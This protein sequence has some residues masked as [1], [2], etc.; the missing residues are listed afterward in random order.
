M[1]SDLSKVEVGDEIWTVQRGWVEVLDKDEHHVHIKDD[2]SYY[3]DGFYD[4]DHAHASA[5]TEYPFGI[6]EIE[7][8]TLVYCRDRPSL[9][10]Y[11][12]YYSHC[13]GDW[14]FVFDD[15]KKSTEAKGCCSSWASIRTRNPLK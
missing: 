8:D 4:E 11:M 13:E 10:W 14:H 12:G 2:I 9:P 6:E 5:F 15:Q 7:K 3:L 1:K